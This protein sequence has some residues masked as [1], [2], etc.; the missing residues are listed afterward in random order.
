MD[1]EMVG[2][3]FNGFQSAVARV[4]IINWDNE[5]ILDTYVKVNEPITDYRTWISGIKPE[6][7]QSDE[8]M[9]FESCRELV[10]H[11]LKDKILVGHGLKNDL[12][13]L[14][15]THPWYMMRDT[16]KYEPYMKENFEGKLIARRLRELALDKLGRT[17]QEDG[18][19]HDS[20]IDAVAALD[21]YKKA[22]K[23]WE[24]VMEWKRN[25]SSEIIMQSIS[26]Q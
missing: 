12:Q 26:E 18:Q 21:L 24:K 6:D 23:R 10:Q 15:M 11:L 8:A 14:D 5:V 20:V 1:C 7:L 22:R 16:V 4:S 9:D 25:K 13:V 19:S 2:I 17:I 3:G